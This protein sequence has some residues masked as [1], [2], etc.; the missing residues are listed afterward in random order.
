MRLLAFIVAVFVAG[1]PAAA[2]SWKEYAYPAYAFTV[3]IA[4][5]AAL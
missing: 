5:P 4:H 1:G 2:Q 3:V